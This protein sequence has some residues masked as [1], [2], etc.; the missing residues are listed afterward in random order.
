M[1]FPR[2]EYIREYY[3]EVNS[4]NYKDHEKFLQKAE[5]LYVFNHSLMLTQ[6]LYVWDVEPEEWTAHVSQNK[7]FKEYSKILTSDNPPSDKDLESYGESLLYLLRSFV[8]EYPYTMNKGSYINRVRK[9]AAVMSCGKNF[10]IWK[11][12]GREIPWETPTSPNNII[13]VR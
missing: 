8:R 5:D 6:I 10:A 12:A 11:T 3:P 1:L 9:I 7:A 2:F 4:S 13:H